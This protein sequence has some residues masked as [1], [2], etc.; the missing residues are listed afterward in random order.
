MN[1]R[2]TTIARYTLL[3]AM[4]TRLP[5]LAVAAIVLLVAA[6][7]F[8]QQIAI[9]E[10]ARMQAGTYGA[11]MRLAC[12][13]IAGLHVLASIIREFNDKGLD[14]AL[15]LDVPRGHYIL[16][17]LAG[18]LVIGALLAAAVSLPLAFLATPEA[19]LQWGLS[20]ALELGIVIA[21]ALFCIVTFNQLMPAAGF[22][23]AFY[24]LARTLTAIRLMG[25]HPLTGADAPSHQ[26]IQLLVEGLALVMP[27]LD[28][29]TRT[30]WLVNQH[31][32]WPD[33]GGL[34]GQSAL[35]IALLAAAAMFDF[36]RK[37]F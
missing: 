10:S 37:N 7:F 23:L 19:A 14:V 32:P 28:H 31:A 6:S 24:L 34:A 20:L 13:F 16:G 4:R 36:Y 17:K 27:A 29:W 2:I 18:F 22:V 1:Q 9:T 12:V 11:G 15:A 25:A 3:E 30:A 35:Y 26:I 5:G 21:L 8:V 33:I